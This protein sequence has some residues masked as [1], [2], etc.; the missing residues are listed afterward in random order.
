MS[1]R[2]NYVFFLHSLCW[3]RDCLKI[4]VH[5]ATLFVFLTESFD[6]S[7]RQFSVSYYRC[8]D[9]NHGS[10]KADRMEIE[11]SL[12]TEHSWMGREDLDD[13]R[14]HMEKKASQK[15]HQK[16]GKADEDNDNG[17]LRER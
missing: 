14:R 5:L 12:D 13:V 10:N 15:L 11:S 3:I 6:V 2:P 9:Q 17:G 16:E 7:G 4:N 8:Q 1:S